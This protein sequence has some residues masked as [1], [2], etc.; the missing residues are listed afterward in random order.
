MLL[1]HSFRR[2]KTEAYAACPRGFDLVKRVKDMLMV[3]RLNTDS[4]TIQPHRP[5]C[6]YE[7]RTVNYCGRTFFCFDLLQLRIAFR[8]P[9][10][11]IAVCFRSESRNNLSELIRL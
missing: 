10:P 9:I 3:L 1:D 6:W 5:D 4:I 11:S 8:F 2:S 7:A